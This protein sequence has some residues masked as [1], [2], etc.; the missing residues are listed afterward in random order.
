MS[1]GTT[2][3]TAFHLGE[4]ARYSTKVISPRTEGTG[5]MIRG[6]RSTLAGFLVL[7]LAGCAPV[8]QSTPA[9]QS[10]APSPQSPKRITAAIKFDPPTLVV[11]LN[12]ATVAGVDQLEDL[13]NAG[14]AVI[15]EH[16]VLR[17]QLAEAVPSS[18]NGLWRVFPDGTMETTWRIRPNVRWHDGTPFTSDDLVFT[19]QV[20]QDPEI[21]VLR[22]V[23]YTFIAS[24]EAPDPRTVTVKWKQ[25]FVEADA[26]FSRQLA[27]P[28]PK[29]IL[30]RVYREEK[31]AFTDNPYFNTAFVGTGPYRVHEFVGGSHLLLRAYDEYVFGRPRI[32]EIEVKF[33]SDPNVLVAN[34]LAGSVELS[35][36][37][38]ISLEQAAQ[39]RDQ[40]RDGH[41][42]SALKSWLV[43]YPQFINSNPQVITDVRFRR[44]LMHAIDRQQLVDTLQFGLVPVAH[45]ILS[46]GQPQ[47]RD[48]EQRYVVRYDYDPR[49]AI[50]LVEGL[51]YTR[52]SDGIFRDASDRRLSLEFRTIMTDINQKTMLAIAD[53]WQRAGIAAETVVIPNQRA[54]DLEYRANF[55]AVELLRQPDDV[56]GMLR[57]H[58]SEAR[59]AE[60]GYT[61]SNNARYVNPE[62]D[63]LL[64]RY[65]TTIPLP[66]RIDVI[67]Q[68]I[69]HISDQLN[70]MG[71]FYDG[72]PVLVANRVLNV[73]PGLGEFATQSWNAHEWDVRN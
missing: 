30:E 43:V 16:D 41:V 59:T 38:G 40:W 52:G 51:G 3:A 6:A 29:H 71:M 2:S 12:P 57:F 73:G 33:I 19:A 49:R 42:L 11:K 27:Q 20:V 72:Q 53:D 32:D 21:A 24:V 25:P 58:G 34:V 66:E 45:G 64:D 22:D 67:G 15:G 14:L 70:A 18:D 4:R 7:L 36:G 17:P 60:R 9:A 65:R 31:P 62:L 23:A 37:R 54:T 55:P 35:L 50:Q 69:H 26:L 68:I 63:S 8:G 13:V 46:P 5:N 10:S 28:M 48:I 61:G 1:R 39:V 47:Y 44:A 56:R